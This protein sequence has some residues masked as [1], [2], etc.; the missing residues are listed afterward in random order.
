MTKH[1]IHLISGPRNVSTALMYSFAQREDVAIIDEPF[2]ASYLERTGKNHPGRTDILRSQSTNWRKVLVEMTSLE[3]NRLFIKDMAHHLTIEMLSELEEMDHVFL[4]RH[5]K[6]LIDSFSRV[7]PNPGIKDIGL[8]HQVEL[9]HFLQ[10]NGQTTLVLDA[11]LLLEDPRVVLS[12]LCSRLD[13]P[14]SDEMLEWPSGGREEDGV[15]ASYWYDSVHRTTGFG[16]PR[17]PQSTDLAREFQD[18]YERAKPPYEYL[19]SHA[20]K[21]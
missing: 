7:I 16:P 6:L 9:F 8:A 3:T 18:L 11:N 4:I 13:I 15:W 17:D 20:I 12:I 2:Y 19:L 1:F 14:F 21:P 10:D 5:P